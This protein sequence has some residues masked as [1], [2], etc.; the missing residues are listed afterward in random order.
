VTLLLDENLPRRLVASSLRERWPGCTHVSLEGLERASDERVWDF[1][2]SRSL[3]IVSKDE[4]LRQRAVLLGS[5]PKV[6][7]LRIGNS[8]GE[9]ILATILEA[10]A[11]IRALIQD[12]AASLLVIHSRSTR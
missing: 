2:R 7:W 6:V 1:A 5:P 12:P 11:D 4:D 8:T 10:D 3:V 9:Q